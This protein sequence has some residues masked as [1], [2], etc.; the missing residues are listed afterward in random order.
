SLRP[1][2]RFMKSR[3]N[4]VVSA[5]LSLPACLC[6]L[7]PASAAHPSLH[8]PTATIYRHQTPDDAQYFALALEA[9]KLPAPKVA[10]R[11]LVILVDTSA[12]QVGEHRRQTLEVVESLLSLLPAEDRVTLF[13][14]DVMT[15]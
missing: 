12:S 15:Q 2:S 11:H 9:P 7:A 14:V 1:G 8:N 6:L 5:I 4:R 10:V 13:A 3:R